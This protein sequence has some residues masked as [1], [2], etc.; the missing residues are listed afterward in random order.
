MEVDNMTITR[1]MALVGS[2]GMLASAVRDCAGDVWSICEL[3]LP[4]FDITDPARVEDVL[5]QVGP[6]VI[7]N[8]AAY[9]NV[10]GAESEET[11]AL[12]VNGEGPANLARVAKAL[13]AS[14]VH[15]ST[16]YVFSGRETLPYGEEDPVAPQSAY[17]RTKLAGEQAILASG[18][19]EFFI[20]RTSW[21]YG[22]AGKN[23]VET[24]IRLAAEREELRI[25]ADQVGSPTYTIDLATA[26][27]NL[28]KLTIHPSSHSSYGIYH[29]SN[30]GECSWYD[31]ACEIV[32]LAR[33]AGL[34]IKVQRVLP[35]KTEE[36]PLPAS[37][38]AYSVFAKEKYQRVTGAQVPEWRSSLAGYMQ[39]R[40]RGKR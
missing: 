4:E 21:L 39:S 31:F 8:C 7:V 29:F 3:D 28:L 12:R 35:I 24:I 32:A 25:V 34:P 22:P 6:D 23:F 20:I 17:G 10:D 11:L 1:K 26:I 19:E 16:D 33:G 9:T 15:I 38:P 37:R 14:L 30:A 13:G 40:S 27:F 36:Y 18:L 2:K 5:T